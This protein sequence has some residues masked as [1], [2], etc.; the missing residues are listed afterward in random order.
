MAGKSVR[1][2]YQLPTSIKVNVEKT[3]SGFIAK[4]EN[5]PGLITYGDTFPKLI[6]NVNDALLTYF[7][8]P[9]NAAKKVNFMYVPRA[10]L[11][12]KARK[13]KKRNLAKTEETREFVR[14][15]PGYCYA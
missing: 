14:V 5:C 7:E 2:K 1:K 13:Q 9:R 6:E 15:T 12:Q 4:V 8:V 10:L 3:S 11:S